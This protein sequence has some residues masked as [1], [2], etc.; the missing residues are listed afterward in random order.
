MLR[1]SS[2]GVVYMNSTVFQY[3]NKSDSID[4]PLYVWIVFVTCY[5]ILHIVCYFLYRIAAYYFKWKRDEKDIQQIFVEIVKYLALLFL[6]YLSTDHQRMFSCTI[7][8]TVLEYYIPF[9]I[10]LFTSGFLCE[11]SYLRVR[12]IDMRHW[13]F[14]TWVILGFLVALLLFLVIICFVKSREMKLYFI[15]V[16]P[17]LVY[18]LAGFVISL[19]AHHPSLKFHPRSYQLAYML[20]LLRKD[21]DFYCRLLAGVSEGFFLRCVAANPMLSLL[22]PEEY[23]PSEADAPENVM[24]Q[25]TANEAVISIPSE[26]TGMD[27]NSLHNPLIVNEQAQPQYES[28]DVAHIQELNEVIMEEDDKNGSCR[29]F[30]NTSRASDYGDWDDRQKEDLLVAHD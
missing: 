21:N 19:F 24:E 5:C 29:S 10:S 4:Y 8:H 30:L 1:K 23:N 17:M 20:C 25:P 6:V 7:D 15:P 11:V 16:I 18:F 22:E 9:L 26:N 13:G 2:T 27:E 3:W 14:Q 12:L 28:R